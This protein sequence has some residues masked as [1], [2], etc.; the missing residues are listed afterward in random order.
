MNPE[1]TGSETYI[2]FEVAGTTY[3]VI[4]RSVQQMEMVEHITP[5]P[6][7]P[8]FVDGVVFTR[9]QVI[10]AVNLRARFGFD[11]IPHTPRTRLIVTNSN[12][13]MVGLIVDSAREFMSISENAVHQPPDS[14]TGLSRKYLKGVV[15]VGDRVVLTIDLD[16]LITLETDKATA[17]GA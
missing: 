5:L 9:G 4:T 12:G 7:A 1:T 6:N 10:P 8:P 11:R 13:R 14:I 2:L 15:S 17:L 16:E 3:G